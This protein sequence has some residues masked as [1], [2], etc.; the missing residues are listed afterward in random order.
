MRYSGDGFVPAVIDPKPL[1]DVNAIRFLGNE[2]ARKYPE[3]TEW[4]VPSPATVPIDQLITSDA[5]YRPFR[6]IRLFRLR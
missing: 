6:E 5:A 1:E 3:V 2:I 4:S